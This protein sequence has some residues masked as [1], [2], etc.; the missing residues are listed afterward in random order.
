MEV[1][2]LTFFDAV[3][4]STLGVG[5]NGSTLAVVQSGRADSKEVCRDAARKI[6]SKNA[7][8]VVIGHAHL[9]DELTENDHDSLNPGSWT[10]YLDANREFCLTLEGLKDE[11]KPFPTN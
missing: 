7:E 3:K 1:N 9:P 5:A 2:W 6:W 10:R 11:K 8:V 4:P